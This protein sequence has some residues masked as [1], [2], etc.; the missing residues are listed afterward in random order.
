MK[1]DILVCFEHLSWKFMLRWNMTRI[2]GTLHRELCTLAVVSCWIFRRMKNISDKSCRE[3]QNTH[4]MCA[5]TFSYQ[6]RV[7]YEIMWKNYGG[8]WHSTDDNRIRRLHFARWR[9]EATDPFRMWN[10]YCF[11]TATLVTRTRNYAM[12]HILCVFVLFVFV[13]SNFCLL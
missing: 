9:T 2:T 5:V 6:N 12:W 8:A 4:F 3:N 7:L 10:T 13:L 11:F 1:F